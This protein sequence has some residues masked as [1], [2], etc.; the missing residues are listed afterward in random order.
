MYLSIR[1]FYGNISKRSFNKIQKK[2][3]RQGN[4]VNEKRCERHKNGVS[5]HYTNLR[6]CAK[7]RKT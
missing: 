2:Y 6:K 3:E 5:D 7:D 4:K 1:D